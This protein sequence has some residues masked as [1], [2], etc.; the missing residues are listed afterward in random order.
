MNSNAYYVRW[1][2]G[3][4]G[5]FDKQ[6]LSQLFNRTEKDFLSTAC[7]DDVTFVSYEKIREL[8][9]AKD[10]KESDRFCI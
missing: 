2:N 10:S 4:I 1:G 9:K 7:L 6:S 3:Y 8:R 5:G